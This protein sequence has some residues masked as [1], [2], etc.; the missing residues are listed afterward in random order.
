MVRARRMIVGEKVLHATP[1]PT[2]ALG[3]QAVAT[4]LARRFRYHI[5]N[6]TPPVPIRGSRTPLAAI[7]WATRFTKFRQACTAAWARMLDPGS[8]TTGAGSETVTLSVLI[9]V[10][11][12]R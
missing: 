4:T 1:R 7:S 5:Q 8:P 10:R 9:A 11:V 3:Q 12:R 2:P 6:T